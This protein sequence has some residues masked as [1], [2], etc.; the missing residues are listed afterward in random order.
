L[1]VVLRGK[2]GL[3]AARRDGGGLGGRGGKTDAEGKNR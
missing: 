2:R 1:D 3:Q